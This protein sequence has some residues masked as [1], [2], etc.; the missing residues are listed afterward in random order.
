MVDKDKHSCAMACF[1][2]RT[3]LGQKE[4]RSLMGMV[5]RAFMSGPLRNSARTR[6][7][8]MLGRKMAR[9]K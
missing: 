8:A 2:A 1:A 4:D 5:F 6:F 7:L 9:L 3:G